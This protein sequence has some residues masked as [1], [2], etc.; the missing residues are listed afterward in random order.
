MS[1]A[2]WFECVGGNYAESNWSLKY[3]AIPLPPKQCLTCFVLMCMFP[4]YTLDLDARG[5]G[6]S[7]I[8]YPIPSK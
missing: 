1:N 2:A 4:R 7:F 3:I 8:Y 6:K 5:R